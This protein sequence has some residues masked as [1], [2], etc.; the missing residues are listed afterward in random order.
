MNTAS[1]TEK[2]LVLSDKNRRDAEVPTRRACN[3][4]NIRPELEALQKRVNKI[5]VAERSGDFIP[6]DI[7]EGSQQ[8]QQG[9]RA[10]QSLIEGEVQFQVGDMV[11]P[12]AAYPLLTKEMQQVVDILIA[13]HDPRAPTRFVVRNI[14]SVVQ[15]MRNVFAASAPV[16]PTVTDVV[17]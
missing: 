10:L 11:D 14:C 16:A 5:F 4:H 9:W 13:K 12:D 2:P 1:E 15:R 3:S 7:S 17:A 8:I 6:R